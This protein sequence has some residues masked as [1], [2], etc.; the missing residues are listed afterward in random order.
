MGPY[1]AH[2]LALTAEH[3]PGP[4]P[5]G[6]EPTLAAGA[7]RPLISDTVGD[8]IRTHHMA[9][10]D[11][12][13]DSL[14]AT[15]TAL[16]RAPL[17]DAGVAALH[18]SVGTV[19]RDL[20]PVV[21]RLRLDPGPLRHL[22]R[23]LVETGARREAV[24]L[25]ILLLGAAR[26]DRDRDL[27]LLIGT[28]E[29]FT[30]YAV[31]A[32]ADAAAV[33]DLGRR[34]T[35][36]GRIHAVNRLAGSTDQR[37]RDWLLRDGYRNDVMDEYTAYTAAT[38]GDLAG[39]LSAAT[40]DDALMSGAGGILLALC[41]GGPA[42]DMRQ[43]T[44]G[45]AAIDGYL[46][47]AA[48]R[49]PH[50]GRIGTVATLGRYLDSP[51]A[52]GLWPDSGRAPRR[53]RCAALTGSPPWQDE[54]RTALAADDPDT[55]RRAVWPA[56]VTGLWFADRLAHHLRSDPDDTHL[57]YALLDDHDE[58]DLVLALAGEVLDVDGLRSGPTLEIGFGPDSPDRVLDLI[59]SRLD[60]YPGRGWP[61]VRA[62]LR[63]WGIRC[64]NMA[65]NALE[66]WPVAVVPTEAWPLLDRAAA[67]EP[68]PDVRDRMLAVR[69]RNR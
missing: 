52:A 54:L 62:A 10:P 16:V 12:G 2:A 19:P 22:G 60:A 61:L 26:D 3:G 38:T 50:L 57:W 56:A 28:L 48:V 59:V 49:P 31:T 42:A 58:I 63:H 13:G 35:G 21:R 68:D 46:T 67:D 45:L 1:L 44:D 40:I 17:T 53:A 8:G 39:A 69:A 25:G 65:L 24:I 15:I 51:T 41:R 11:P 29:T 14:T 37:I 34:V 55:F 20:I 36:W 18:D 4:W 7:A 33:H 66:A 47:H 23:R 9:P 27:L 32:L 43:Y 30:L 6:G 64:R 5:D